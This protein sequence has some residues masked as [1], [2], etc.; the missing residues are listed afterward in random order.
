M[1]IF[2]VRCNHRKGV[3]TLNARFN[4]NIPDD[5]LE[6]VKVIAEK[7]GSSVAAIINELLSDYV[8]EN[9]LKALEER[10]AELERVV[11]KNKK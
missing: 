2:D 9:K 7:R 8:G 1:S 11:F 6:K 4:F 3:I 10:V 5:L